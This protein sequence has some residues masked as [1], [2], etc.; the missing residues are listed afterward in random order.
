MADACLKALYQQCHCMVAP[1][2]AEGFG[3]PMAEAMLCGLPVITTAWGGQMDFCNNETAWLIDYSFVRAKTHF[4]LYDSVWAEPDVSHLA[5]TMREIYEMPA[6]LRRERP[7]MGSAL[8]F[9]QF[10]WRDVVGRLVA[11]ARVWARMP[12]AP[13]PRIGWV[14]TW[15]T[16]CGIASYSAYLIDHLPGKVTILACHA[17]DVIGPDGPEVRRCWTINGHAE[18]STP[19]DQ[20][21]RAIDE[22]DLDTLVIQF[23]YSFFHL[24]DLSSFLFVQLAAGRRIVLLSTGVG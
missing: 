16:R 5:Q 23:N 3:L 19:L 17:D 12:A 6:S 15:N 14:T 11:A 7:A 24:E 13:K 10:N 2:R 1:S 9:K 18:Q 20:L 21:A 4:N 22:Q 8:L